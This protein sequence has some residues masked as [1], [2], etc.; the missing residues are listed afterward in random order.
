MDWEPRDADLLLRLADDPSPSARAQALMGLSRINPP[1]LAPKLVR[2]LAEEK[3]WYV[4]GHLIGMLGRL[5]DP[6]A[7]DPLLRF[8]EHG[9]DYQRLDS[10]KAL[11]RL[12]EERAIPLARKMLQEK[13]SPKRTVDHNVV[14]SNVDTIA[15]LARAAL[16]ASPSEA[17]RRIAEEE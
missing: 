12:G 5:G 1:G 6:V 9:D 16:R 10:L 2:M 4:I 15:T 7:A 14:Q 17:L 13:R 11:A 3:T 8:F